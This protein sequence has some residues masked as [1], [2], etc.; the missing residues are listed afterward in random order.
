MEG[1]MKADIAAPSCRVGENSK[2]APLACA[3][4]KPKRTTLR[5]FSDAKASGP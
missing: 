4:K 3:E 2:P 1:E 5:L